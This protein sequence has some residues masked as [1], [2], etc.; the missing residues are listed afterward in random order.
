M[1]TVEALSHFPMSLSYYHTDEASKTSR[2]IPKQTI[3]GVIELD[4]R[5]SLNKKVESNLVPLH[6]LRRCTIL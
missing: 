2:I 4:T 3:L 5:S 1:V 6:S